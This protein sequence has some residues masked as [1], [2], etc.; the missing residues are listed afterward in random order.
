VDDGDHVGA[1]LSPKSQELVPPGTV[2]G[3]LAK[4]G[5]YEAEDYEYD[6]KI[7]E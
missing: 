2:E 4:P 5:P 7:V 3:L 6:P 1:P